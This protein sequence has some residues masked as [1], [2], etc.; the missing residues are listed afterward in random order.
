MNAP[1]MHPTP[2][3]STRGLSKRWGGFHA[4]SDISLSF[5]P[6]A[7]HALIG[8]N[9]AGKTTFINLLTGAFAPTSGQVL[10]GDEDIGASSAASRA[11]SR[12]TR[13]SRG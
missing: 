10:L 13:C 12:S 9:G 4:N 2:T 3:L 7:R 8:P 6:G 1:T 11:R 5:A